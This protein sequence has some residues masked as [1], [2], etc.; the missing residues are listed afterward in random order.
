MNLEALRDALGE[1]MAEL[2]TERAALRELFAENADV[3]TTTKV[4]SAA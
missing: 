1:K 2:V 3:G 4:W